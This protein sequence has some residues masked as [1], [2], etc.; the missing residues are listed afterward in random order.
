MSANPNEVPSNPLPPPPKRPAYRQ[1]PTPP[2][3]PTR[4]GDIYDPLAPTESSGAGKKFN[5]DSGGLI[6]M[7]VPIVIIVVL[8]MLGVLTPTRNQYV[9][10]Y[11]RIDN[12]LVTIKKSIADL[13]SQGSTTSS[14]VNKFESRISAAEKANT[15]ITTKLKDF[16]TKADITSGIAG[17]ATTGSVSTINNN[18]SGYETRIKGLETQIATL[19]ATVGIL[20]NGTSGTGTTANGITADLKQ[21]GDIILPAGVANATTTLSSAIKVTVTNTNNVVVEDVV[22]T[23]SFIA[24]RY[25]VDSNNIALL[26]T[27]YS[28]AGG[29][30][31]R[32]LKADATGFA[33]ST[34]ITGIKL[35]ANEVKKLYL[36]LTAN[37]TSRPTWDVTFDPE[38]EVDY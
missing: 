11:T 31:T 12:D 10:D 20:K 3:R 29:S 35:K 27:S 26:P 6:S 23:V 25:M 19:Q 28:L 1:P 38:V 36:T 34:P 33:F 16:A 32:V 13:G 22:L 21:Y 7:A 24:D 37:Y 18:I 9:S 30:F 14:T 4:P 17:L 5:F 15:D 2:V 8:L